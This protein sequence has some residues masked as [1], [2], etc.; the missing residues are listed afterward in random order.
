MDAEQQE[1]PP[2]QVI[3]GFWR[4]VAA[5]VVD[6]LLL[7]LLG[8]CLGAVFYDA[9]ASIGFWGRGLG[10]VIAVVYMGLMNSRMGTGQTLGKRA[11]RIKVVSRQGTP[12][13]L[14]PSFLR[15]GVLCLPY[16]LNGLPLSAE[17]TP[18]WILVLLS[19]VIF[20]F[21]GA[22]V[23]LFVF[24]RRSRQSLHDLVVGSYVVTEQGQGG[25]SAT[26]LWRLHG[27]V[28]ATLFLLAATVPVVMATWV[29]RAE[30][31]TALL[32]LLAE[33]EQVQGVNHVSVLDGSGTQWSSQQGK[34][35]T[36]YISVNAYLRAQDSDTDA[37]AN[38]IANTVLT[39]YPG[40][41]SRDVISVSLSH[42]YDIGISSAWRSHEIPLSPAAWRERLNA[43]P[44]A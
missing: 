22:I 25:L 39:R 8:M 18:L 34:K 24:N 6:S 23:Y 36:T 44:D 20:G 27:A 15:A 41:A 12:L 11:L 2:G 35:T 30:P 3:A 32:P 38:R 16:F 7:G 9:L 4:R 33:L 1:L 13:D 26:G 42:G 31:F 21:G 19:I 10:F 29:A 28:V 40:A 14:G 17:Q 43:K 37:L 5:A